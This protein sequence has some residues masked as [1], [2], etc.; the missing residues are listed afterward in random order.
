MDEAYAPL[1]SMIQAMAA[2]GD[3]RSDEHGIHMYIERFAIETPVELDIHVGDDGD[4]QI[5]SAP[6]LYR[7]DTS[8]RPSFHQIRFT[9]ELTDE[10]QGG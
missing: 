7:V 5:G 8:L 10:A 6:P 3:I 2:A 4:L 9:A 1:H